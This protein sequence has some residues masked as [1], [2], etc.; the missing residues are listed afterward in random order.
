MGLQQTLPQI[1]HR[2]LDL[3]LVNEPILQKSKLIKNQLQVSQGKNKKKKKTLRTLRVKLLRSMQM[4]KTKE[5]QVWR[6]RIKEQPLKKG[7]VGKIVVAGALNCC[8][9]LL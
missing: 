7:K 1:C 8:L 6:S 3:P 2:D 5:I 4:I 9:N